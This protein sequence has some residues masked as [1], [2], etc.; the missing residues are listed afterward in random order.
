MSAG[1]QK[2]WSLGARRKAGRNRIPE[3]RIV[4]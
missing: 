3:I 1:T 4:D 2:Q